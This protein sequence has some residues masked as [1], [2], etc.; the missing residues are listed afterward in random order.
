V[1]R[2]QDPSLARQ[3]LGPL[4]EAAREAYRPEMMVGAGDGCRVGGPGPGSRAPSSAALTCF[5]NRRSEI[6]EAIEISSFD[7]PDPRLLLTCEHASERFPAPFT[8]PAGD[9]SLRGTH[10]AFDLGAEDLCR[11]LARAFLSTAILARF[12]RLIA[13]PNRPEDAADLF[14]KVADGR[15]VHLNAAITATERRARMKLWTRYHDAVDVEV[16]NSTA[17]LLLSVHTFTPV[18]EGTRRTLEV[19]VLFDDDSELAVALRDALR[20]SAFLTELNE[21]Y[22]GRE[23]LMYAVDRH[24]KAHGRRAIEIEVRQDLACDAGARRRVVAAIGRWLERAHPAGVS[25]L[26]VR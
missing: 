21:P 13:D 12:S 8:W 25:N 23:G 18:Y 3:E 17:P 5:V 1:L 26:S 16:R 7:E 14:R 20:E 10:W 2:L 11:D 24:A 19:G 22:S 9:A 4:L 15:P 6:D